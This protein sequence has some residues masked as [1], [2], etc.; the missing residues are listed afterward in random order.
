MKQYSRVPSDRTFGLFFGGVFLLVGI[1][2]NFPTFSQNYTWFF[3]AVMMFLAALLYPKC[4]SLFNRLW[5]AFGALLH[6]V[7]NPIM[8]GI[9]FFGIVTPLSLL[10][11]IFGRDA[12]RLRTDPKLSSYWI[13]RDPT[14][15]T[16]LNHQ[17]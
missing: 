6:R 10:T 3:L 17:F 2:K 14:Q 4:L 9:M 1:C 16:D 11:K 13:T 15:K 8:L 7:M 5:M 12:L